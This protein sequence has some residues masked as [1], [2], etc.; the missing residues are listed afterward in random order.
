MQPAAAHRALHAGRPARATGLHTLQTSAACARKCQSPCCQVKLLCFQSLRRS[1]GVG[2]LWRLLPSG[3]IPEA[4]GPSCSDCSSVSSAGPALPRATPCTCTHHARS[5]HQAGPLSVQHN[6]SSG[7]K[8]CSLASGPTPFGSSYFSLESACPFPS[9]SVHRASGSYTCHPNQE[10][11]IRLA[12]I[13]A[14]GHDTRKASAVRP[15][16]IRAC[17]MQAKTLPHPRTGMA[18]SRSRRW[19]NL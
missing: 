8:S 13:P 9:H 17:T 6:F 11:P 19:H 7:L 14:T 16:C 18:P 4:S 15:L 5:S 10:Q 3:D 2:I 12:T 1:Q